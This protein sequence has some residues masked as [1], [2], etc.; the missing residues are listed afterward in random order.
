MSNQANEDRLRKAAGDDT[1][2]LRE[3]TKQAILDWHNKQIEEAE[4]KAYQHSY[5]V[6]TDADLTE[7]QA[8]DCLLELSGNAGLIFSEAERNQLKEIK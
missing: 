5:M 3:T 4:K 2:E 6:M 7:V 1:D 8:L